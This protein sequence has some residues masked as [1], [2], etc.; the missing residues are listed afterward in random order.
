MKKLML[1]ALAILC[2]I[3]VSA[4]KNKKGKKEE[5]FVFTPVK[6][7]AI[8]AIKDQNRSSTCW[9][10]SGIG[11][12]EAELIRMGKG[13]VDFSEMFVV[14]HCMVERA[15]LYVRMHGDAT[16]SPGGSFYDVL[17]VMK[18]HGMVPQT[19]MPG[20]MYGEKLPVHNELDAVAKG[21]IDAIAKKNHNKLTPVWKQGLSAI[22]ETYLGELPETFMVEGK[23][24][25]PKTYV[26]SLELNADDY[27]SLTSFTH[28][29]FYSQFVLEIPDNWRHSY[30]YNLPMEELMAVMKNAI[31]TGYTFAWG[32]DVSEVGFSRNGVAVMPDDAKAAEMSGSDMA[33]WT[34]MSPVDKREEY[35]RKPLP[36]MEITQ[37]MRQEAFDNWETT[38]DH[39]MLIYGIAK[40]QNG[41]PY[42][43]MKNSWGDEGKY[44]GLWYVS[45]AF[46][47]Y[48]T[49]NIMLHKDAIPSDIK[50]KLGIK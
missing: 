41:K 27:V 8:S 9:S 21:Y 44:K 22:Y 17:S 29:P 35:T 14:Y 30:S 5:G 46:V 18:R 23:E 4:Q 49:M 33:K 40:D 3:G 39:G 50:A 28:H 34:G 45:E 2:T 15:E 37:E 12:L 11:L 32:A 38:D 24:M 42:F 31:N 48:K 10:F 43:M 13:E 36:E 47:N 16:F 25:T 26:E 6:E 7:I 20:I 1:C 19:A